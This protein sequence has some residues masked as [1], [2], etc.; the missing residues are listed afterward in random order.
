MTQAGSTRV[1]RSSIDIIINILKKLMSC[2][3]EIDSKQNA[4]DNQHDLPVYHRIRRLLTN[5]NSNIDQFD[6]EKKIHFRLL[7]A[8]ILQFDKTLAPLI[9]TLLI[10][11]S[12]NKE[13]LEDVF[14]ILEENL[15]ENY[16][17]R[18]L[19]E[20]ATLI[21]KK[22]SCPFIQLLNVDE[23][24][25]LA[26]WFINEKHRPL[27]VFDLLKD[28]V[29]NQQGVDREQ[30]QNLLKQIRQSENLFLRQQAMEY[31]VPWNENGSVD[32]DNDDQMSVSANSDMS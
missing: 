17:E 10:K 11:I 3:E 13:D 30:C 4:L 32:N 7:T 5:I 14:K 28:H 9:G 6:N 19:T 2:R 24:L 21:N 8:I 25:H 12:Q 26:Q 20:F 31:T 18:I 16:F 22:D 29:F 15:S 1:N 27:F 23:K